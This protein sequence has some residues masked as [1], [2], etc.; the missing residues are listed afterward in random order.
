M[1]KPQ[2]PQPPNYAAAATAQGTAN[3]NSAIAT[4]YLNQDNQVGPNGSLTYSYSPGITL[5]DGT[6][7]PHATATTTLSPDQQALYDQTNKISQELNNAAISGIGYATNAANQPLNMPNLAMSGPTAYTPETPDQFNSARDQVTNA[8]MARL[9]PQMQQQQ[10]QLNSQLASQGINLGSEA[11]KNAQFNLGQQQNDQ[12]D[13]ALLSGDQEEQNLFND[14]LQGNQLSYNQGLA[15]NQFQNQAAGQALQQEAFGQ[16]QPLNVLNALRSGN[17]YSLPQFGN[18]SGGSSIQP[19]PVY[20]ATADQ[21]NAQMQAYQQQ[22]QNYSSMLSGLGSL[23][24]AG[25]SFIPGFG[26]SDR[27]LKTNI[28]LIGTRSDGLNLYSFDLFGQ[29]SVGVMADE[30]AIHRPDALGPIVRGYSTVNYGV[31]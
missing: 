13:A 8:Y 31:L 30:V 23:G 22:M 25:M 7:I 3:E 26:L 20:Q 15:S 10:Q 19:A 9:Q 2:A 5:A 11:Y 1:S 27:R 6:N 14:A 4:N 17:Q 12:R 21:Y 16:T 28:Q 18:V 29:P 24:G